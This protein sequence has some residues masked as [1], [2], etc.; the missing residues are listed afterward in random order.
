MHFNMCTLKPVKQ[1]INVG[2]AQL[3][4]QVIS[5]YFC[6][7]AVFIFSLFEIYLN[8]LALGLA[9]VRETVPPL[10]RDALEPCILPRSCAA[11]AQINPPPTPRQPPLHCRCATAFAQ[12]STNTQQPQCPNKGYAAASWPGLLPLGGGEVAGALGA[13]PG[14]VGVAG[15]AALGAGLP[16]D[17]TAVQRHLRDAQSRAEVQLLLWE[18]KEEEEVEK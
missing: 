12:S 13:V 15:Q 6:T 16:V 18:R 17:L 9:E 7:G 11:G 14:A 2:A 4:D 5:K 10:P 3:Q 8:K 1:K